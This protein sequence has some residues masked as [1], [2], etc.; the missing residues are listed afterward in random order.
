MPLEDKQ[1]ATRRVTITD[2]L[3]PHRRALILGLVAIA[4]ESVADVAAPWPLKIVL[5]N[6][7]AHK[8]SHGWLFR[9]IKRTVGTEAHGILLFACVAVIVIAVVDAFF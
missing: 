1:Q 6:V 8:D 7:I 5:D 2:L 4:G 3:R 9:F